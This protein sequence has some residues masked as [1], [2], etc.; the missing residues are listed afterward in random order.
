[1]KP[2]IINM[3]EM[4]DSKEV[5][6]SK[7]GKAGIIFLYSI[8]ALV[9]ISILWMVFGEIDEV[10]RARGVIRPNSDISTVVN[11]TEGKISKVCVEDGEAVKKGDTLYQVDCKTQKIKKSYL[12]QQIKELTEKKDSLLVYKRSVKADNNLFTNE[13]EEYRVQFTDYLIRYKN[14][15]H[16]EKYEKQSNKYKIKSNQKQLLKKRV[17]L[18]FYKKLSNSIRQETNLFKDI[19]EESEFYNLYQQYVS[20]YKKISQQYDIKKQEIDVSTARTGLVNSIV[21][22]TEQEEGLELLIKSV[23]SGKDCFEKNSSYRLKY[24]E[25]E[26]KVEQ[27]QQEYQS[28]LEDYNLNFEL[29][30]YGISVRELE[31]SEEKVDTAKRAISAFKTSFLVDARQQLSETKKNL[32]D[33][34]NQKGGLLNKK[35]L[36]RNNEM[37]KKRDLNTYR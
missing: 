15:I 2:I 33:T 25:Y 29:Q 18:E 35:T 23:K 30:E 21:Y 37:Q 28:A 7:P 36:I 11:Q 17:K 31:E 13:K 10:V 32:L 20:G 9:I 5:Y 14:A 6:E 19:G 22:Y 4:S 3:D 16:S 12:E 26:Q 34:K 1:M 8:F 24:Q 27:L